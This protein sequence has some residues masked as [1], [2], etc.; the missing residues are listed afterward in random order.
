M[1]R[2]NF[3]KSAL[4]GSVVIKTAS[5]GRPI[6]RRRYLGNIELS[7]IGFGGIVVM[8]QEQ[9][10]VNRMVADSVDRGINY[11]DVAPSYGK[12]EAQQKLGP[13]LVPHRKNV[14]LA[15]KTEARDAAGSQKQL[16]ESLRVLRTDHFDLYQLHGVTK[17]SDVEQ[18]LGPGGALE[19]LVKA[20]EQGKV[21]HLGFSAHSVEAALALM[22]K[23]RFDSILFPTNFVCFAQGNF[24]PQVIAK[25]KEKGVARLA[26]KAMAH[27]KW[28][29]NLK[30]AD[31]KYPKCWYSPVDNKELSIQALRFTLSEDIT[32]AVPPGDE[33]LYRIALDYAAGFKPLGREERTRLL[34]ATK[35]IEPIFRA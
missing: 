3:L 24:G 21:R 5:A 12:G 31:R 28:P 11:F 4:A 14:F 29:E 32:A 6:P 30:R 22:D 10:A 13:A 34:A 2:R 25:A 33:R 15:C 27:T 26:L 8:G 16:E 18:I 23:F 20:R 17:M 1:Q 19:T 35:G 9:E 7:I